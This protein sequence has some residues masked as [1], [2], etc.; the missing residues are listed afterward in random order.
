[1]PKN[2]AKEALDYLEGLIEGKPLTPID[3]I[4]LDVKMPGFDGLDACTR[5]KSMKPFETVP[6]LM[7]SADEAVI[8]QIAFDHPTW[9][10]VQHTTRSV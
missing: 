8:P 5:I 7:I 6:I 1:V 10:A 2:S 3:L 9:T 4:L